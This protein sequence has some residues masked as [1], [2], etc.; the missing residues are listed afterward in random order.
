ML[1]RKTDALKTLIKTRRDRKREI[2]NTVLEKRTL[3]FSSYKNRRL[4]SWKKRWHFI[5]RLFCP[6]EIFFLTFAFFLN[7]WYIE[8]TF[9]I[10]IL[11][12]IKK[13]YFILFLLFYFIQNPSPRIFQRIWSE[14]QAS[15]ILLQCQ[16]RVTCGVYNMKQ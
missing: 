9:R 6:K 2:P 8:Y 5:Y 16:T 4:S 15:T 11:L 1:L 13:H 3:C 14:L 10:Y 12:Q 7:V